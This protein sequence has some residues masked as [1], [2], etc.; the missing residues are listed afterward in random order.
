MSVETTDTQKDGN[1]KPSPA[2][3]VNLYIETGCSISRALRDAGY[4][5][6]IWKTQG[7][8]FWRGNKT[9][10]KAL[11]VSQLDLDS[12]QRRSIQELT[13]TQSFLVDYMDKEA[14]GVNAAQ[15]ANAICKIADVRF[16]IA[17]G[18]Y[19]TKSVV[20][21]GTDDTGNDKPAVFVIK[22]AE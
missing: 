15:I 11:R 2:L 16:K 20:T 4:A 3:A 7:A 19:V 5:S 1:N 21:G 14:E 9:I 8:R 17:G 6:S 22:M 12:V 13:E 10:Q 18:A